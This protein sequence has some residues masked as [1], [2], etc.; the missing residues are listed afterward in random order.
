M[1]K[2]FAHRGFS[3]YYPENTMLAFTKVAEETVADGIELDIQLTKDG[4]IVIMH[5]ETLDRTTNASGFLKDYTLAELKELSVGV[6]F[7][8]FLPRQTIPT[9]REF[10]TFLKQTKLIVNIELKTSVFEYEGIEEKLIALVREFDLEEQVW[11]SSFNHYTMERIL[12]LMPT[13]KC[14]LLMDTWLRNPADYAISCGAMAINACT[15]FC[16]KPGIADE[17]HAKQIIMQAWTPNEEDMMKSLVAN[18]VDVLITN[19]PDRAAKVLG[20]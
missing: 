5:D 1:T 16:L 13:A 10:F 19:Y 15:P 14:G 3:A 20:R 4:E 2:I 11:Y 6:N 8:G 17:L 9:L 12:K 7:K 18:H